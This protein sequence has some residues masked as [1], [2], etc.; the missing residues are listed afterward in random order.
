MS[1]L[2]GLWAVVVNWNG[3]ELNL[4]CLAS[5]AAQGLDLG[6]V[7]FVDNASR[8][9]SREAVRAAHPAVVV[10]ENAANLGFGEAANQGAELALARGADA[11]IYVNN[12][13]VFETGCLARLV[14]YLA[15][16]PRVGVVGPRVLDGHDPTRVWCAGGRLDHRQN[17]S[18][19]VG[20]GERDGPRFRA[21]GPVDYVPGCALVVR[22]EVLERTGGY[23]AEFF[24]YME[25][26]DLCLRVRAAGWEV[27]LVGEVAALHKSSSSTGGGYNARRKYMMGV[28]TVRF[29]RKHGGARA[30]LGFWLYD[31]LPLPLLWLA[32]LANGAR[33]PWR[34]RRAAS[35]RAS[36]ARASR[37]PTRPAEPRRRRAAQ[38]ASAHVAVSPARP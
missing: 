15:A 17:L 22:R 13:L 11:V 38:G 2:G 25:D 28:N 36:P 14:D 26:V 35:A 37:R 18:K 27:H 12:D 7:V 30:W 1:A 16:H 10:V 29:L 20:L 23:D 32:G 5:L 8:D 31:V 9:G 4:A 33:A 34:R 6:H 3:G 21:N 24:A 19:L